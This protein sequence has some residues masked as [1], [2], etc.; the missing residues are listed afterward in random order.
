MEGA[1]SFYVW[2]P[3]M[4]AGAPPAELVL[5]A[6]GK[7]LLV[8]KKEAQELLVSSCF[9]ISKTVFELARTKAYTRGKSPFKRASPSE[10]RVLLRHGCYKSAGGMV[11]FSAHVL[12]RGLISLEALSPE[13]DASF[14]ELFASGPA[15]LQR[16]SATQLA[17]G[18][19]VRHAT[20]VWLA[21]ASI[22]VLTALG[23]VVA[24]GAACRPSGALLHPQPAASHPHER[25]A[26][27]GAAVR[28]TQGGAR[29]PRGRPPQG[30]AGV[31]QGVAHS[32]AGLG[33][34]EG[35]AAGLHQRADVGKQ[36]GL[37][38]A[39]FGLRAHPPLPRGDGAGGVQGPLQHRLPLLHQLPACSHGGGPQLSQRVQ[40]G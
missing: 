32:G 24:A 11:L 5:V 7:L 14:R 20:V 6:R 17:E 29:L 31:A 10:A 33:P 9:R 1:P 28:P 13:L 35:H 38:H 26:A 15:H 2:R 40:H 19:E 37:H 16:L 3:N 36:G 18:E 8:A 34:P 23:V 12:R 21:T 22:M 39:V 25:R 27:T 4:P 30:P